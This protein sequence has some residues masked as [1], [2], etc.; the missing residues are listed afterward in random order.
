MLCAPITNGVRTDKTLAD[1]GSLAAALPCDITVAERAISIIPVLETIEHIDLVC[2]VQR[3]MC[4]YWRLT[5]GER[6]EA[7]WGTHVASHLATFF[8]TML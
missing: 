3:E 2:N 8:H 4:K 5:L 6:T 7:K 1:I